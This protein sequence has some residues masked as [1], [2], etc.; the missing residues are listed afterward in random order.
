MS[1]LITIANLWTV[2]LVGGGEAAMI[3]KI[4]RRR[5]AAAKRFKAGSHTCIGTAPPEFFDGL[6]AAQILLA[7]VPVLTLPALSGHLACGRCKHLIPRDPLC[8]DHAVITLVS[9]RPSPG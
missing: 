3:L 7:P 6:T 5:A 4:H 1:I 2:G 9:T 8:S